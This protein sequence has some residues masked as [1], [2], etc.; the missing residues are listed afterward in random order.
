MYYLAAF[1]AGLGCGYI[2]SFLVRF[3]CT[4]RKESDHGD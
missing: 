3:L 1:A 4:P 2:L